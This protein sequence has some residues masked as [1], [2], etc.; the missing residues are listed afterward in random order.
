MKIKEEVP[1]G[2]GAEDIDTEEKREEKS[3]D[4]PEVSIRENLCV[5]LA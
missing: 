2:S 3:P 4:M 1:G 5:W